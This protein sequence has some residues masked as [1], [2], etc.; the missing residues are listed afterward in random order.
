MFIYLPI[1]LCLSTDDLPKALMANQAAAAAGEAYVHVYGY[2]AM[3][4]MGPS[5]GGALAMAALEGVD[6]WAYLYL[7]GKR[8]CWQ[9]WKER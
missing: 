8:R 3:G 5:D 4:S 6:R 2:G 1:Y 7:W 9:I